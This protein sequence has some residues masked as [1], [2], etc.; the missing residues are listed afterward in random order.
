M[1]FKEHQAQHVANFQSLPKIYVL[2]E[3]IYSGFDF[4]ELEDMFIIKEYD[5]KIDH[6][7]LSQDL[8][9]ENP[10]LDE[11]KILFKENI[12]DT[13]NLFVS[14]GISVFVYTE[15]EFK[16]DFELIEQLKVSFKFKCACL[17]SDI[18]KLIFFNGV[19]EENQ[20]TACDYALAKL[21]KEIHETFLNYEIFTRRY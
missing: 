3:L 4:N 7:S 5:I 19:D 6:P 20:K 10:S 14:K 17:K 1:D 15:K 16:Y 2:E 12:N 8:K 18:Y 21:N 13:L 11:A 9:K